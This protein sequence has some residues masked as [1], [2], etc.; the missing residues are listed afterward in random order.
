VYISGIFPA[1][2]ASFIIS[3]INCFLESILD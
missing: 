2:I 3:I 1:V